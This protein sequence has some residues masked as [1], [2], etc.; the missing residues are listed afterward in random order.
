MDTYYILLLTHPNSSDSPLE[1]SLLSG[2]C[3]LIRL[4]RLYSDLRMRV[5]NDY[6]LLCQIFVRGGEFIL[7]NVV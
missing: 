1:F 7:C 6:F 4:V 2:R 5:A 3:R